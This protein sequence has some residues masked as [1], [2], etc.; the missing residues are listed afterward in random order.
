MAYLS[1]DGPMLAAILCLHPVA[2]KVYAF[3][4]MLRPLIHDIYDVNLLCFKPSGNRPGSSSCLPLAALHDATEHLWTIE[5]E[6]LRL[7][8]PLDAAAMEYAERHGVALKRA[9]N[10]LLFELEVREPE[11]Y[12]VGGFLS[13]PLAAHA[14]RAAAVW[15]YN[16]HPLLYGRPRFVDWEDETG[17]GKKGSEERLTQHCS[18]PNPRSSKGRAGV[19]MA[20]CQDRAPFGYHWLKGGES[21]S[22]LGTVLLTRFPFWT[23]RGLTIVEDDACNAQEWFLNRVP[24]LARF[25]LFAVDRFHSG[26][27]SCAPSGAKRYATHMC[28]PTI[29][30]DSF[31]QHRQTI[32]TALEGIN[33]GLKQC[34]ASLQQI[35]NTKRLLSRV[36]TILDTLFERSKYA[37]F[38]S[39]DSNHL[40]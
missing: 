18:A 25:M 13:A 17:R 31:P 10:S 9:A 30:I 29:F 6:K 1:N 34:A 11:C 40:R 32:M 27:V 38:W 4:P 15:S 7:V 8:D 37:I 16:F 33:L 24:Q 26:P 35:T 21:V 12:G 19:F 20:C 28:A 36:T 3:P 14:K 2:G 23:L 5:G 39:Q 22:D